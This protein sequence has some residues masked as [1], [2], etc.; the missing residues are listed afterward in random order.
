[1]AQNDVKTPVMQFA[2]NQQKAICQSCFLQCQ[3]AS[4]GGHSSNKMGNKKSVLSK[5][6]L[7]GG[8]K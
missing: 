3:N 8:Y 1:M 6:I 4:S 5:F 7:I 2:Y